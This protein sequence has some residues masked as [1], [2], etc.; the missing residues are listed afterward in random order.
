[1][2]EAGGIGL[3]AA[4]E[5]RPLMDLRPPLGQGPVRVGIDRCH[6][7]ALSGQTGGKDLANQGLADTSL[8]GCNR[9]DGHGDL[10]FSA[11]MHLPR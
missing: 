4:L 10:R 5:R 8:A 9:Y 7:Q 11:D 6:L 3:G 1:M 2:R